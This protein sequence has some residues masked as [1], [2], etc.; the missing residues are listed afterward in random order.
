MSK[1]LEQNRIES[2]NT[3]A[4]SKIKALNESIK[5]Q[6]IAAA[7]SSISGGQAASFI[8]QLDVKTTFDPTGALN[9]TIPVYETIPLSIDGLLSNSEATI[10]QGPVDLKLTVKA[11]IGFADQSFIWL[12][13]GSP[14]SYTPFKYVEIDVKIGNDIFFFYSETE[15][16][17]PGANSSIQY[18]YIVEDNKHYWRNR[19]TAADWYDDEITSLD[20]DFT[21]NITENIS[22]YAKINS[23]NVVYVAATGTP[24]ENG[25]ALLDAYGASLYAQPNG[26]PLSA[27]NRLKIIVAPGLYDLDAFNNL[28]IG[29]DFIDVVSL[30]GDCDVIISGTTNTVI[31][32]ADNVYVKG[33]DV[34]DK[35]FQI[36]TGNNGYTIEN[37]KGGDNSFGGDITGSSPYIVGG[38]LINCTGGRRAFAGNGG[39]A[40]GIFKNCTGSDDSFAGNGGTANGIFTN[41]TGGGKSFGGG[42]DG[43]A[44]GTFTNCVGSN[45]SFGGG[46]ASARATGTFTD[47]SAGSSSF[48][49]QATGLFY[50]CI[51][52]TNSFGKADTLTGT[53][54]NCIIRPGGSKFQTVSSGGRTYYC[55]GGD[56]NTDNQ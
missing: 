51:A 9:Y 2:I 46:D 48:G 39:V 6:K 12:G 49:G 8:G 40:N 22:P 25:Q 41:C 42:V 5:N 31:I 33:I 11:F 34:L 47:C 23:N 13:P 50:R 18:L 27:T 17:L 43:V 4:A 37:C 15:F 54:Y 24:E 55:I 36:T 28:Y 56:G 7:I 44:S 52:D 32:A 45:N 19:T 35:N 26:D 1:T 30:T 3:W 21:G 38:T 10:N 14:A 20:I 16:D 53:L 29:Y